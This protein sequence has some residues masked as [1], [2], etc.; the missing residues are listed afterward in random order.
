[1]N[2]LRFLA[3]WGRILRG[4][5]PMLSIEITRECP[6]RCPGCYAYEDQH[7]GGGVTLRQL[8][9]FRGDALI[10]GVLQLVREHRPVHLSIVG[11]EPLVRHR[12]LSR[13]LPELSAMRVE[14]L[15]VTSGVIPIPPEW[16]ELDY[17]RIAVSIDGLQP[18]HD[19]RRAPATYDRILQNI[20]RRRVDISWVVTRQQA[21]RENYL[22]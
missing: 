2:T 14:T 22:D 7:L 11:G 8:R 9:D 16:N 6:L 17:I 1:M 13:I 5:P 4:Q 3:A 21:E 20:A 10:D 15:V 18:D 19:K 12:E